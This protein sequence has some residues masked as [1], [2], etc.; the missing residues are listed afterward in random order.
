MILIR[1]VLRDFRLYKTLRPLLPQKM[2]YHE[3]FT[4]SIVSKRY[5]R[6]GK[7][8]KWYMLM[9]TRALS[10]AV[11]M[12]LLTTIEIA[13]L[14]WTNKKNTCHSRSPFIYQSYF[15]KFPETQRDREITLLL[16]FSLP[17]EKLKI[18]SMLD[19]YF[20]AV[21]QRQIYRKC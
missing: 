8:G 14:Y 20:Q 2:I 12:Q 13:G 3:Y 6:E 18:C 9:E 7:R 16:L 15:S 5:F 21:F 1:S 19:L 11:E 17:K 4:V 10:I